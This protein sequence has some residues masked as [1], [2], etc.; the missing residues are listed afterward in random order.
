MASSVVRLPRAHSPSSNQ[1]DS[2]SVSSLL[3]RDESPLRDGGIEARLRSL[4]CVV[5]ECNRAFEL[6]FI[7]ESIFDLIGFKPIELLGTRLLCDE[8]AVGEDLGLVRHK[9]DDLRNVS[10]VSLT[11]RL[12]NREGLPVWVSHVVQRSKSPQEEFF[13]GCLLG[14]SNRIESPPLEQSGVDLFVHKIGN[15]FQ[16]IQLAVN[17]LKKS[18]PESRETEVLAE[19]VDSAI[20]LVRNFSQYHQ[21][22]SASMGPVEVMEILETATLRWKS[23]FLQKGVL[24]KENVDA[25]VERVVVTGDPF[26]LEL[27]ISHLLQNALEATDAGDQVTLVASAESEDRATPAL[28]VSV[29]DSGCG[30][31]GN[32][33][34]KVFSPFFTT[35]K[36]HNGLGLTM[37][38]RF[39]ELHAGFVEVRSVEGKG[40][41]AKIVLPAV[42]KGSSS[43]S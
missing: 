21:G 15:H 9:M 24:F 11:H 32:N 19:A 28:K 18:L 12:I 16:L 34:E 14:I 27:A 6:T 38:C 3:S 8:R 41:E 29:V 4:P 13:R 39:V 22:P 43:R 30:I 35:R 26:V 40:T 1:K 5:Y 10:S 31:E 37:A 25:A 7:S 36:G 20:E 2:D 17:S 33:L 42:S 23:A